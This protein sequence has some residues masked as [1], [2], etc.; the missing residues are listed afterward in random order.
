MSPNC[1]GTHL[2]IGI[3]FEVEECPRIVGGHTSFIGIVFEVEECPRIVG[4]H[5][6]SIGIVS[7]VE[8]CPRTWVGTHLFYWDSLLGREM[9]TDSGCYN[10][11]MIH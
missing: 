7:E 1:R 9:S 4:G 8:E 11:E 5:T 3:V 10:K 2:S 6:S